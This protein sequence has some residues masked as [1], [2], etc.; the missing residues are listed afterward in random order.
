M[1]TTITIK[2]QILLLL[3]VLSGLFAT[4]CIH[5]AV[6]DRIEEE[7]VSPVAEDERFKV[8]M[9]L[10]A[11]DLNKIQLRA[12]G[13]ETLD[14]VTSLRL[15]VFDENQ[16]FLYSED[17]VLGNKTTNVP[18]TDESYLPDAQKGNISEIKQFTVSLIKSSQ[19]RY[20]H[21]IAN[22][23]WVGFTQDYFAVGKSAGEMLTDPF[24]TTTLPGLDGTNPVDAFDPMWSVVEVP[25]LDESTFTGKVVKLLRNY[26][27]ISVI[28]NAGSQQQDQGSFVLEGFAVGNVMK[29]GAVVPF[30]TENYLFYFDFPPNTPTIPA[31][32][33]I[34]DASTI[35]ES[36]LS[37]Q[38]NLLTSLRR[39]PTKEKWHLSL[40]KDNVR[41]RTV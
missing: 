30:R 3:L 27:K 15:L 34:I 35:Q 7:V 19:K 41:I 13:V 25:T 24:M 38:P 8:T 39:V 12:G 14:G 5:E 10:Q 21:F 37:L 28:Y 16:K 29:T 17:A 6:F 22:H 11:D 9:G 23:K 20:I 32:T 18:T 36:F 31:N 26:A 2:Y 4:S 1:R 40:L 33:E